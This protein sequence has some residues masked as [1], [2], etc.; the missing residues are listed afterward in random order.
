MNG[1]CVA[2]EKENKEK[3]YLL[4]MLLKFL[5]FPKT[6]L[7]RPNQQYLIGMY[8]HSPLNC[9][10]LSLCKLKSNQLITTNI[11]AKESED[12]LNKY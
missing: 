10:P 2:D 5:L 12:M 4:T 7:P 9:W 3:W 8:S 1:E 6:T 11:R